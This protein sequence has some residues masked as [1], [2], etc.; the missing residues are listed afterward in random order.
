V[1]NPRPQPRREGRHLVWSLTKERP[2]ELQLLLVWLFLTYFMFYI[3][4]N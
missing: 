2:R 3:M 1:S 4:Y